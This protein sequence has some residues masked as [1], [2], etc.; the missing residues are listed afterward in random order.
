MFNQFRRLSPLLSFQGIPVVCTILPGACP[1][2]IILLFGFAATTGF[3]PSFR[4]MAHSVHFLICAKRFSKNKRY[5][6]QRKE[7]TT[8]GPMIVLAGYYNE[9]KLPDQFCMLRESFM[10][11]CSTER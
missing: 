6:F 7:T 2:I 4:W 8:L 5:S 9:L 10:A 3:T 1:I 11:F